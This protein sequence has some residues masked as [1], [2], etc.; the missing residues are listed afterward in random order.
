MYRKDG[1][2][3]HEEH[4]NNQWTLPGSLF[5]SIVCITTIGY[6]DQTPK[7]PPGKLVT[8]F[9]AIFGMPL[10]WLCLAKTGKVM[11]HCFRLVIKKHTKDW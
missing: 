9:Y 10:M 4:E 1:W 7:T 5:Y 6:G 11:A 8:V 2:N 3:G